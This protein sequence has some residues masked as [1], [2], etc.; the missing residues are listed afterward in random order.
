MLAPGGSARL[1]LAVGQHIDWALP[2]GRSL[3]LKV[4]SVSYQ[5]EAAGDAGR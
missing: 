5:P 4:T 1:G 3:R 2:G